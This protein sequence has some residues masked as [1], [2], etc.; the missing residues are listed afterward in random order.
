MKNWYSIKAV[1]E[2]FAEISVFDEIGFWGVQAKDFARE[3]KA[4]VAPKIKLC[5]NSP[6][7]SVFDAVMMF[8]ILATSGKTIE[9]HV[10]G[11]A[12]SAASY[13]AMVGAKVVMPDNTFMF[14]H[15]PMNRVYGNA[16]DMREMADVLDKI[17]ASL[18]AT[19]AKRFKGDASA[20]ADIL[21]AESYLTAA[22]CLEYGLCDE[23]V[24]AIAATAKFDLD[25]VPEAVRTVAF[26]P[27]AVEPPAVAPQAAAGI[28]KAALAAAPELAEFEAVFAAD[29]SLV[30]EASVQAAVASA[31]E[32]RA[33]CAMT[34]M[35][36]KAPAM[37]RART[38]VAD[39][40][41]ALHAA[42]VA[43]DE[44]SAIDTSPRPPNTPLSSPAAKVLVTTASIW[45]KARKR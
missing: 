39:A 25:H 20:L 9:A 5:I 15:N 45:A 7:G 12:A 2:S 18:T 41:A 22:E 36:D 17:G 30:D 13:L 23:V 26:K 42:L 38:S 10:L 44:G 31:V 28:I 27:A 1:D 43:A 40:R 37:I 6:G 14:L 21:A 24:D 19:Y 29:V 32:V 3:V 11:V 34:G 33:F 8:N 4:I 35:A 16:E